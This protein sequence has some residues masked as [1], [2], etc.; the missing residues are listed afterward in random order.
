MPL[1]A[2]KF[3]C[4]H[5][6]KTIKDTQPIAIMR[7]GKLNC[8]TCAHEREF[9]IYMWLSPTEAVSKTFKPLKL[10]PTKEAA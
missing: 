9:D 1:I 4:D 8:S 6:H 5:C 2:A 3:E 10:D 7:G